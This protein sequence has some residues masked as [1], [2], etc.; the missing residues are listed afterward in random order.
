M[1]GYKMKKFNILFCA[2]AMFSASLFS[3][4]PDIELTR[5]SPLTVDEEGDCLAARRII[6]ETFAPLG[7]LFLLERGGKRPDSG[8]TSPVERRRA[9]SESGSWIV[10]FMSP[11]LSGKTLKG[12]FKG[13]VDSCNR[14]SD[15]RL[16]FSSED[17][18]L[19]HVSEEIAVGFVP[20]ARELFWNPDGISSK[21]YDELQESFIEDFVCGIFD[22]DA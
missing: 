11:D 4:S 18:F 3:A 2:L 6:A 15:L 12:F 7:A 16:G 17:D 20:S 22:P 19:K 21:Y 14:F 8:A 1:V 5:F 10:K 9:R 13:V